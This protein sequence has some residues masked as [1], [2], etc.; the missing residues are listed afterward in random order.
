MMP[1][2]LVVTP[3]PPYPLD[4]GGK[5][6]T[7]HLL[8]L[9]SQRGETALFSL[10]FSPED[11]ASL[12]RLKEKLGLVRVEAVRVGS[13][14]VLKGLLSF[15]MGYPF[16]LGKYRLGLVLRRLSSLVNEFSPEV[17]HFDH[18]HTAQ[19]GLELK[20]LPKKPILRM[21]AHNVEWVISAR[22]GE[23]LVWPLSAV[24]GHHANL[25]RR[26]EARIGGEMDEVW[27][28]SEE[29]RA[30][31]LEMGLSPEK[32]RVVP[33]GVDGDFWAYRPYT[34][35]ER[36]LVFVGSMDWLPN[37]DGVLYFLSEIWPLIKERCPKVRFYVVGRSPSDRLR[38]Y[39]SED[40]IITGAV[41]DVRDYVYRSAVVVVPL[42]IGGGSRLKILEA[43]SAGRAVVSTSL[44]AEGIDY[45]P[46]RDIVIADDPEEFARRVCMLLEDGELRQRIGGAGRELV[47]ERYTWRIPD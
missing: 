5:I 30:L 7:Y 2:T 17:I 14:A 20:D 16:V 42:R 38:R 3:R 33:N 40:V 25:L 36:D 12:I 11:T 37:E 45:T 1:R 15:A 23:K 47:E 44:G 4:T 22:A 35:G 34:G 10:T 39:G 28:V 32:V 8:R 24:A 27:T 31:F 13:S 43:M 41:D 6:R 18:L 46:D 9:I 26:W 21:D 19:Y 29:D